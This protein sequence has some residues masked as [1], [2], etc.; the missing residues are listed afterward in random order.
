MGEEWLKKAVDRWN[1]ANRDNKNRSMI[2]YKRASHHS[3]FKAKKYVF[4]TEK[5][6]NI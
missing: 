6:T 2:D 5:T 1:E 4:P 3:E